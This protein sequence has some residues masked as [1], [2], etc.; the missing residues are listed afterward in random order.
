MCSS[1]SYGGKVFFT[2]EL[3]TVCSSSDHVKGFL[4]ERLYPIASA[5]THRWTTVAPICPTN[6]SQ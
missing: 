1:I 4:Y 2:P 5:E 3:S 6:L